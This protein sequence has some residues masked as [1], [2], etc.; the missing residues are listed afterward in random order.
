MHVVLAGRYTGEAAS[1]CEP[2]TVKAIA[3][4]QDVHGQGGWNTSQV[5][6]AA[7][8]FEPIPPQ[9]PSPPRSPT[10]PPAPAQPPL[11][12][13]QPPPHRSPSPVSPVPDTSV[14]I[15][16]ERAAE[17]AVTKETEQTEPAPA[18]EP[19]PPAPVPA[20]VE[21]D[22]PPP[23]PTNRPRTEG[24]VAQERQTGL[25][26]HD[27]RRRQTTSPAAG[28]ACDQL[29]VPIFDCARPTAPDGVT[30][31]RE[32]CDQ[33]LFPSVTPPPAAE[34][35][36]LLEL[37]LHQGA[38][39]LPACRKALTHRAGQRGASASSPRW[40]PRHRPVP[41]RTQVCARELSLRARD[42]T[43]P[44]RGRAGHTRTVEG[45]GR[46]RGHEHQQAHLHM[47]PRPDGHRPPPN[48]WYH[49]SRAV[50]QAVI[51]GSRASPDRA[52]L[53]P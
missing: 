16:P 5:A 30:R 46:R 37:P 8:S 28:R 39:L 34:T 27:I 17:E 10:P 31:C 35:N 21:Q 24:K 45:K 50:P 7:Y 26:A 33:L 48:Q 42:A 49:A 32:A 53:H 43:P 18:E 1:R 2:V 20:L 29:M 4:V 22:A 44:T 11:Q 3:A 23:P 15:E 36:S 19:E 51:T 14:C 41:C 6:A 38:R 52:A 9:T 25:Y 47:L 40:S 13:E 12:V